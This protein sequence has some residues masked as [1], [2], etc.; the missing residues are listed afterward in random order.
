MNQKLQNIFDIIHQSEKLDAEQKNTLLKEVKD[1]DKELEIISFKLERTEK[2][3]KTT[4]ILL[5]ETIQELEQKRKIVEKHNRELE[6]EAALERVRARTMAM[7]KSE[8]LKEVIKLV[9]EQ[10]VHLKIHIEHTG[11]I[12]DYKTRDDL[13]IWLAD[14]R[15]IPSEITIP[16]FDSPP[17]NSI[18]E[19]KEKGQDF[20]TYLL[21]FEE[22]NK[23]YHDLFKFIPGVPEESLE[24]YFN[25]P[26]L[27]G[28]GVLLENIGLYI[29]NFSGTPYTDEENKVLMRFGKVFQQTYTRFL[30]LQKAEE[31]A[32]EAEIQLALERVR[33]RTMA[34]QKSDELLSAASLLFHQ[35]KELGCEAFSCGF[36]LLDENKSDGEF[37]MS[38]EGKFQPSVFIPNGDESAERNM[39]LHWVKGA[40]LYT[41]DG[42]GEELVKHFEYLMSLPGKTGEMFQTMKKAGIQFPA[43]QRWHAAYFS[44]GYLLFI[45][46]EIFEET[47]IFPRFA[48]VFEQTYA[49]FLD[50]Q[51]AEAQARESE[52]Q[53]ALERVRARTMAMHHSNEIDSVGSVLFHQLQ[54]LNIPA[55]RGVLLVLLMKPMGH[56]KVGSH[57]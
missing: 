22:K 40:K 45:T 6:I 35:V 3:K 9:Y 27:A 11:F 42:E 33:A 55:L 52:I 26:G 8:E 10:F 29:E 51:K 24:Y 7:Q 12:L 4:A 49:R 15:E 16:C 17:N 50:L 47:K 39:Y 23:F 44:Q 36:V 37:F 2:V 34:M 38:A 20:F 21:A 53:L 13:H 41:E 18:K 57:L 28:S 19:A 1:A 31:Q 32:R 48:S 14:Q 54:Q 30:D 25:C 5:E 43:W 46:K 56:F